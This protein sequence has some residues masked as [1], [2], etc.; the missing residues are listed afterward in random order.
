ML[1]LTT[2]DN[3]YSPFNNYGE[4][5]IFD[6]QKGYKSAELLARLCPE[7]SST[8]GQLTEDE[9]IDLEE[10]TIRW[11][12]DTDPTGLRCI[13]DTEPDSPNNINTFL[14]QIKSY[15]NERVNP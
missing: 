7:T 3:P 14:G 4:W 10:E 2:I 13:V 6:I 8:G 11:I 1:A 12:V 5:H 15:H 9:A